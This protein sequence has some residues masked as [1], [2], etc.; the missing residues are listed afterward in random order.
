MILGAF[1]LWSAMFVC[2]L[3]EPVQ[4]HSMLAQSGHVR[5]LRSDCI[6]GKAPTF[7]K[8]DGRTGVLS[9]FQGFAIVE[10]GLSGWAMTVASF[11]PHA[12]DRTVERPRALLRIFLVFCS[13][14]K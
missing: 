5:V 3:P 7:C 8:S 1:A 13:F 10:S 14:L 6:D 12:T 4:A 2:L 11:H 9:N